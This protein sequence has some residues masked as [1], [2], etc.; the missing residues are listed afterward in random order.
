MKFNLFK[1]VPGFGIDD[2]LKLLLL[3][4]LV[5]TSASMLYGRNNAG[6]ISHD[7]YTPD[8]LQHIAE[9][10]SFREQTL[11]A[12][13]PNPAQNEIY[14]KYHVDADNKMVEIS[15]QDIADASNRTF[16]FRGKTGRGDFFEWYDIHS[17][18]KGIYILKLKIGDKEKTEKI[19]IE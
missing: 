13:Y 9:Q 11:L 7:L 15:V 4:F 17:L 2:I 12:V 14:L 1:S 18:R 8:S 6:N 10:T 5:L 3:S 19:V 16:L